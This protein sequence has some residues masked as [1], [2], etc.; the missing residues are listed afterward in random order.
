MG[1]I[2]NFNLEIKLLKN[3]TLVDIMDRTFSFDFFVL[4]EVLK[5]LQRSNFLNPCLFVINGADGLVLWEFSCKSKIDEKDWNIPR[6]NYHAKN[7]V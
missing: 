1:I 5:I 7:A 6:F 4:V 3:N 2:G